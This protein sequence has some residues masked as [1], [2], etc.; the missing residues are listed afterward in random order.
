M[1]EQT[2]LDKLARCRQ[3]EDALREVVEEYISTVNKTHDPADA[4]NLGLELA[5]DI[6]KALSSPLPAPPQEPEP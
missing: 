1:A 5:D 3:L 2:L 4:A 6:L